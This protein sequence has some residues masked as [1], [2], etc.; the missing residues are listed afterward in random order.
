LLPASDLALQPQDVL[1]VSATVEGRGG[2]R[3][4]DGAIRLLRSALQAFH[5]D[6]RAHLAGA[7][8]PPS[9]RGDVL[10]FPVV[11]EVA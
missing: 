3:Y 2:C 5:E 7:A 4:P 9:A 10:Q 1:L 11:A 8:C 6:V